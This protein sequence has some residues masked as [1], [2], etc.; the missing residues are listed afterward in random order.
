[1]S[2]EN[3]IREFLNNKPES[4]S[5]MYPGAENSKETEPMMQGSSQK[6]A[7]DTLDKGSKAGASVKSAA[8]LKPHAG[9]MDAKAPEQGS[10]EHASIDAE[11]DKET[12]GKTQAAK[13]AKDSTLPAGQGAGKATNFTDYMDLVSAVSRVGNIMAK[14]DVDVSETEEELTEEELELLGD[15]TEEELELLGELTE[16]E[17]EVL[18]SEEIDL[19]EE[20]FNAL[21]EEEQ[22]NYELVEMSKEDE[23]DDEELELEEAAKWRSNPK[24]YDVHHDDFGARADDMG[25]PHSDNTYKKSKADTPNKY[26]SLQTRPKP[27]IATK[28]PGK[29]KITKTSADRLKSRIKARNEAVV[30]EEVEKDGKSKMTAKKDMLMKKIKESLSSDVEKLFASE[31]DLSEDFKANA[32]SLFE[33][34][35]TARVAFEMDEIEESLLEESAKIVADIQEELV[36]NVDAY[37]N[38]VAEQWLKNNELAVEEGLRSEVTEDF[39]AGLKTLFQENY[40]EIPEEKID[41]LGEMQAQNEALIEKVNEVIAES[42]ELKQELDESKRDA[43]FAKVTSD[44]AQTEAEKLH[45]LVEEVE[46]ENAAIF[47]QKLNV[48]KNN[49]FPKSSGSSTLTE[50]SS[51]IQ[52]EVS[53][54]V[55]KYAQSMGRTRFEK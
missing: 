28:G 5:E 19:T 45:G 4:L 53:A 49:Y 33:A 22:A 43:I 42:I 34:V 35:V 18:M 16:E 55:A 36:N 40:I 21:S 39:I 31:T 46:F 13:M 47:E 10:S 9:P 17:L 20:E 24:A 1:M 48:I 51:T 26:G 50:D 41:V 7:Y 37:L 32:A 54:S 44:L 52:E 30:L 15:L 29:G 8:N 12:Q 14:E 23:E 27:Q 25:H 11:T 6:S 2:V 3:K 38:F